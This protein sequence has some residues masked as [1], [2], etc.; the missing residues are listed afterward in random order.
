MTIARP[1]AVPALTTPEEKKPLPQTFFAVAEDKSTLP[2]RIKKIK[3]EAL[4]KQIDLS[5]VHLEGI[6]HLLIYLPSEDHEILRSIASIRGHFSALRAI[7]DSIVDP[8]NYKDATA[9]TDAIY[10]CRYLLEQMNPI[11]AGEISKLRGYE[12]QLRPVLA[13]AFTEQRIKLETEE[14]ADKK[15]SCCVIF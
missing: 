9:A 3:L 4:Q 10:V 12:N 5:Q 8:K 11:N 1:P 6:N 13:Q 7:S 15:S 2:A 14:V